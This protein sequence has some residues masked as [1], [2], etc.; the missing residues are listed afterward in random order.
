MSDP[1][2]LRPGSTSPLLVALAALIVRPTVESVSCPF[3]H[4]WVWHL[5][6]KEQLRRCALTGKPLQ[7]A[8]ALCG[9]DSGL[10]TNVVE[11]LGGYVH[12]P[13]EG[14]SGADLFIR[15]SWRNVFPERDDGEHSLSE[16]LYSVEAP[17]LGWVCHYLMTDEDLGELQCATRTDIGGGWIVYESN[18][19]YVRNPRAGRRALPE[20]EDAG[21]S[22]AVAPLSRNDHE[23]TGANR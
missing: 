11:R 18:R 20:A 7:H 4:P 9:P 10:Y 15:P 14:A 17:S 19:A 12:I 21:A 3:Q 2:V 1:N 8:F 22:D 16:L 6:V 23:T 13:Y 5:L